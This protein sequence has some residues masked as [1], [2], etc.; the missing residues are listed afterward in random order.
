[1]ATIPHA[2]LPAEQPILAPASEG[3]AEF[4]LTRPRI[5]TI[6]SDQPEPY[7]PYG[8]PDTLWGHLVQQNESLQGPAVIQRDQQIVRADGKL[9]GINW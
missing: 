5:L 3:R 1:M 2:P 7:G 4:L 9:D 8:R 6:G